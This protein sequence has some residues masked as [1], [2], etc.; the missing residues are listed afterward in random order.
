MKR[1]DIGE[2]LLLSALW[3]GS[4]LFMRVAVPSLGPIWLIEGRVLVAGLALLPIMLRLGLGPQLRCHWRSLLVVG[5]LNSAL[6][7]VLL[8]FASLSLPAGFTSI[9]NATAPLF[10]TVIAVVWLKDKLTLPPMVGLVLGFMGVTILVGWKP[11]AVTPDFAWAVVAGLVAA[12]MYA[13]AAP[14]IKSNLSGVPPLVIAT[15]SQLGAACLLVPALPFTVPT[16]LPT[17]TALASLLFLALFSTSLAYMLYFRLIKNIGAARA[18]TVAYLIPLFAIVWGAL[19][20][21]EP[22]TPSM[23]VGCGLI[24]LGTA[25]VNGVLPLKGQPKS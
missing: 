7:F 13:I 20:L 15:G 5:A 3:G 24:L 12:V 14:Y 18:L 6:P 8:A 17:I 23:G 11:L 25:A 22:L 16:Q 2:L 4:F 9:L 1:L 21:Q 10:G 19:F